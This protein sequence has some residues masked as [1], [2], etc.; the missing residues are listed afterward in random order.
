MKN[1]YVQ[2]IKSLFLFS[3]VIFF[4]ACGQNF[5]ITEQASRSET[6][7][8]SWG[9]PASIFPGF[10]KFDGSCSP[11]GLDTITIT[12]PGAL[13]NSVG[14]CDCS[15]GSYSCDIVFTAV[16]TIPP[17]MEVRSSVGEGIISDSF[18]P[19]S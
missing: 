12:A 13:P 19:S 15:N 5:H 9:T 3:T 18:T 2:K 6:P 1:F 7:S 10:N 14:P 17:Q 8:L 4:L 16:P 11:D